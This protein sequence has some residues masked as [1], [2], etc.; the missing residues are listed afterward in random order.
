MDDRRDG[1][2]PG[3]SWHGDDS[4]VLRGRQ[5][6][7]RVERD[8]EAPPEGRLDRWMLA[9]RQ[10]VEGVSG[11]R[12][13]SRPTGRPNPLRGA[14]RPTL[15]GLG[16]WVEDRIDWLTEDEDDWPEPWQQVSR[17]PAVTGSPAGPGPAGCPSGVP[18]PG[19]RF[20]GSSDWVP[21]SSGSPA[22]A[23]PTPS[24]RPPTRSRRQ[25]LEA[26]SRRGRSGAGSLAP[27]AVRPGEGSSR[28]ADAGGEEWPEEDTFTVQRWQRPDRP[29][30]ASGR[31]ASGLAAEAAQQRRP[32]P[33]PGE[34]RRSGRALPR[35]TR[36]RS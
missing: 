11:T 7:R 10:I 13:G 28:S 12:P 8:S 25:P 30:G 35:S 5:R 34:P 26:I 23:P 17:R 1:A 3:S 9:G 29:S 14:R 20:T 22:P 31:D 24:Q 6:E 19:T 16:R 2:D 15:E 33:D 4:T 32:G 21:V 36:R 18:G 27:E